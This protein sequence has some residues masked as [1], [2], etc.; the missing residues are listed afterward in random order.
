M[1]YTTF[2]KKGQA[3]EDIR[4]S[5]E[6]LEKNFKEFSDRY[7]TFEVIRVGRFIEGIAYYHEADQHYVCVGFEVE[8]D[9]RLDLGERGL[10]DI[11]RDIG[12][13]AVWKGAAH[14]AAPFTFEE[15]TQP[16]SNVTLFENGFGDHVEV[17]K[18][19]ASVVEVSIALIE[20]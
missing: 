15:S 8:V 20:K 12:F 14:Q 1:G 7:E 18:E 11:K 4:K 17:G 9:S 5:W 2:W 13:Y 19:L 3:L 16:F 6:L 10:T